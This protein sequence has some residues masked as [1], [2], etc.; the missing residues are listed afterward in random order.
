MWMP[1]QA[2]NRHC[3][4]ARR[5]GNRRIESSLPIMPIP[6]LPAL[7]RVPF[8]P[9]HFTAILGAMAAF[10]RHYWEPPAA[11]SGTYFI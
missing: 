8:V 9:S 2:L 6:A 7:L 4:E 11:V 10:H 1:K 5:E 3:S